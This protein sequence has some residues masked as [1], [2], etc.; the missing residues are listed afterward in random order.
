MKF[1]GVAVWFHDFMPLYVRILTPVTNL[2][3]KDQKFHW[4]KPQ[5]LA[6]AEIIQLIS[7]A[8]ILRHFDPS[9]TTRLHSNA[10]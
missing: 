3:R 6:I 5:E 10:S 4:G 8:P 1:L 2:L 9:L 7:S